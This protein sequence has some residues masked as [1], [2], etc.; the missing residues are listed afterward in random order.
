MPGE[1]TI[2]YHVFVH[3]VDEAGNILAQ[4]DAVPAGWTRPTTGWLPGEYVVDVHTLT[5][6]SG[7]PSGQLAFRIGLYD[8]VTGERLSV[9]GTDAV[10]ITLPG[11]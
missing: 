2:G 8:P 7:L 11:S 3:L 1:S 9:N 10:L 6:P 5:L 4:S